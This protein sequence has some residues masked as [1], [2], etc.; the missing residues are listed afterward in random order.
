MKTRYVITS[1]PTHLSRDPGNIALVAAAQE[2]QWAKSS[3]ARRRATIEARNTAEENAKF[4]PETQPRDP[5]GKFRRILAR[6][7]ANLGE[8][9][10]EEVAK[11]IEA[12]EAA[13]IAGNYEEMRTYGSDLIKMVDTIQ[14][15]EL[16]KGT[17]KNLRQGATDLGKVLAYLPLPQG[18]ANAKIRFTDMPPASSDMVRGM[19]ERVKE[20][21]SNEDSKKYTKELDEFLAGARTMTSDELAQNLNKLLRVLA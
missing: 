3:A 11:K 13:Q 19:L 7:K 16:T 15:G 20:Q 17:T 5:D 14:D 6:L 10:T 12:T 9:G 18:N 21:L 4:T 2:T 8:S 1:V